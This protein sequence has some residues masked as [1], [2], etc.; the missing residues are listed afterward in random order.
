MSVSNGHLPRSTNLAAE[1][2]GC[3]L[4]RMGDARVII[5]FLQQTTSSNKGR[6]RIAFDE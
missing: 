1:L 2:E 5:G 4:D 3:P 6:N